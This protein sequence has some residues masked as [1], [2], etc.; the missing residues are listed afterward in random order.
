L[1]T[2]KTVVLNAEKGIKREGRLSIF[3]SM[4]EF[5]LGRGKMEVGS[6]F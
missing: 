1:L 6:T 4:A 2:C 5:V 3:I